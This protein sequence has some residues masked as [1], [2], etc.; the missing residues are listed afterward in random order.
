MPTNYVDAEDTIL[1]T[2]KT[3]WDANAPAIFDPTYTPALVYESTEADL[4]PHPRDG[5]KAWARAVV[6]ND[7]A[8]KASL[9]R[10]PAGLARYRRIGIAWVQ[11]FSPG[12]VRQRLDS[13]RTA[14][15]H[16]PTGVRRESRTRG[17]YT[18]PV[19]DLPLDGN[20]VRKDVKAF[21]YWDEIH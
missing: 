15:E 5:T 1:G 10:S 4:K 21:F 18:G 2:L 11:V 14:C 12:Q 19:V 3:A 13:G 7:D 20:W 8:K 9:G 6:R 17:V 16:R